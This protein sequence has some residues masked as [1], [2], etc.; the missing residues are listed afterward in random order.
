MVVIKIID[1]NLSLRF[2]ITWLNHH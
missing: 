1:L 2:P